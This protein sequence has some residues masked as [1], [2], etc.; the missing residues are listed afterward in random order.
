MS[1]RL[2]TEKRTDKQKYDMDI[3]EFMPAALEVMEHPPS[4]GGR[5]LALVI[6]MLFTISITWAVVG[7]VDIVAVAE[8]KIISSGRIKD[9][10]PLEKGIVK[11]IFVK[12]GGSVITGQPLIELD[13]TET[14][15]DRDRLNQELRFKQL[16]LLRKKSLLQVLQE[17]TEE[18]VF[19]DFGTISLSPSEKLD[20]NKLLGHAWL[21]YRS[22][23]DALESE[24][25][26]RKAE[27]RTNEVQI[28]KLQKTLPLINR[29]VK[30][31][32]RLVRKKLS[33]E[34]EFLKLEQQQIEQS[35]MLAVH[36]M[37]RLQFQ[38][39]IDKVDQNITTLKAE[40]TRTV[41]TEI[42]DL[43]IDIQSLAQELAKA[44]NSNAKQILRSPVN[45]T[46]QQLAVHTIGGVVTDAQILMK[47]V[48]QNDNLEVEAT[49]ENK[50]I[51]YVS[52]GQDAEIK[53]NTFNFTKYG[54]I[55]AKVTDVTADAVVDEAKGLV[56]KLRL[57]LD[58]HR[59][60]IDQRMVDLIPGMAVLA[61]V[62]TG[63][64]RIIEYVLS[65]LLR[66]IDESVRER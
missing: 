9:I 11:N 29:R 2:K 25:R 60:M 23:I 44:K 54:V 56:Y 40:V 7:E 10:Q 17:R 58:D 39:A 50:D 43:Q 4:K 15:A 6:V 55:N 35:Q 12:E 8:G 21:D 18:P 14:R 30:A 63:K 45:G 66:K 3:M 64:R 34:L 61:E 13:K 1:I 37:K 65:P 26:E 33:P 62:K 28:R 38:A 5:V 16:K 57:A 36:E 22:R 53:V 47:I 42:E 32:D 27:Y 48:P 59:M 52:K 19:D 31:M 49:L 51:G 24:R 41:L 20:Q 46:V